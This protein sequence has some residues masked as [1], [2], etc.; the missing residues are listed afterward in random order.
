MSQQEVKRNI[1]QG[2]VARVPP[3]RTG[4]WSLGGLAHVVNLWITSHTID[5]MFCI[6]RHDGALEPHVA[7]NVYKTLTDKVPV[8]EE[9]QGTRHI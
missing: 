8:L 4:R 1:S 2:G 3:Y 6:S 5:G 9:Q 7:N